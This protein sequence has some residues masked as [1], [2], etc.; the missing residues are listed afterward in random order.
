VNV[1]ITNYVIFSDSENQVFSSE[2]NKILCFIFKAYEN[3]KYTEMMTN[4]HQK[5]KAVIF[6]AYKYWKTLNHHPNK[7]TILP[8]KRIQ[9]TAKFHKSIFAFKA[10]KE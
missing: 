7:L 3:I 8:E 5:A 6:K 9:I 2:K 1:G 4:L 10:V